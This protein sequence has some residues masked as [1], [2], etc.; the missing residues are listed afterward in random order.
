ML[1]DSSCYCVKMLNFSYCFKFGRGLLRTGSKGHQLEWRINWHDENG[2]RE[3]ETTH[4]RMIQ[5]FLL[6]EI[7]DLLHIMLRP[8]GAEL[9][10][11]LL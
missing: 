11:F 2:T 6:I 7:T 1:F 9:G 5:F 10:A 8:Q 3:K 4:L